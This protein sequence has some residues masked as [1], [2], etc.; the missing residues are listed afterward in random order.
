MG[1][2][3]GG[4]RTFNLDGTETSGETGRG[5]FVRKATWTNDGK[6]LELVSKTTFQRQDGEAFT[7]TSTDKLELSADGKVLTLTRRNEGPQGARDSTWVM[8]KQ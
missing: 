2:G 3:M 7:S 6:T 8:N 5:K 1:G 4:P